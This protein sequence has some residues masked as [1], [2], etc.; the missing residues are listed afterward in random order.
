M[1]SRFLIIVT[2]LLSS[3]TLAL[4][5]GNN[6]DIPSS[7]VYGPAEADVS[8]L[9]SSSGS[10]SNKTGDIPAISGSK[11][12]FSIYYNPDVGIKFLYPL[13]WEPVIKRGSDNSTI[14]E[15]LFPNMTIDNNAG[16]FSS[17]HRHG[18]STSFIV[19][20]IEEE[21]S[22][23]SDDPNMT[24]ALN[25]LTKQNLA[26]ANQTL[27]NFQLIKSYGT[28]IAGNPA[29][30]I[31]YSF[32]EPSLVTPSEFVFQSMNIWTIKGDKKYTISY[33]QPVEEYPTYLGIVQHMVDSFEI[34]R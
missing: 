20:S 14:I 19:L 11:I 8:A 30:K 15:I 18:P 3:V 23:L 4:F 33:S 27:A 7:L 26:L 6:I 16:K 28:T 9:S 10:I 34:I 13:G 24:G 5:S 31:V 21:A 32:T 12:K 2:I 29:H 17:G 1:L 25:S 22:N